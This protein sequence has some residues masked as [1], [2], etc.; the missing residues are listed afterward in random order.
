MESRASRI[1]VPVR[2]REFQKLPKSNTK[3]SIFSQE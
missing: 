2:F 3:I 1:L